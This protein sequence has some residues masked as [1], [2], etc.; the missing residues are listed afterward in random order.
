V[1]EKQQTRRQIQWALDKAASLLPGLFWL[2]KVASVPMMKATDQ[3]HAQ[4]SL[5]GLPSRRW[6]NAGGN[7][8]LF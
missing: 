8:L 2:M 3:L 5:L 6:P 4:H 1:A 7:A